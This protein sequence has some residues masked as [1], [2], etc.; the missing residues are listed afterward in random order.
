MNWIEQ[1]LTILAL[2]ASMIAAGIVL[3]RLRYT[4]AEWFDARFWERT[5]EKWKTLVTVVSMATVIIWLLIWIT[6][7]ESYEDD[8]GQFLNDMMRAVGI[9]EDD[10]SNGVPSVGAQ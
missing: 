8:L 6:V 5:R 10:S 2:L 9:G 1:A 7:P 4:I 3:T